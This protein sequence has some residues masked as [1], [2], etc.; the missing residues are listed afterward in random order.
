[1]T[2]TL[3]AQNVAIQTRDNLIDPIWYEKLKTIERLINAGGGG[4]GGG[5]IPEAP[6]DGSTYGRK[7]LG[8]SKAL[9]LAGGTLTGPLILAADPTTALGTATKQYVDTHAGGTVTN[10]GGALTLNDIVL[11][12]GGND[13]K[14][15]GS[16]GT[17]TTLLHGNASGPPTFSAVDLANDIIGNLAISHLN[18]SIGASSTTFWRGD[19]T[20]ATPAGGGGGMAIGGAVISGTPGSVLFIDAGGN[21][22]QDNASFFWDDTNYV[23]GVGHTGA[24]NSAYNLNGV[25]AIFTIPNASGNNWFEGN[26]GNKTLTG[27]ANFGTGDFCL[28]SVTNAYQNV[29]VGSFALQSTQSDYNNV[30]LGTYA[31]S[32]L[33]HGGV[34]PNS[35]NFAIGYNTMGNTTQAQ[36]TIAIGA[37]SL[38][39]IGN[40][41]GVSDSNIAIGI[42]AGFSLGATAGTSTHKNIFIGTNSGSSVT[43][44]SNYNVWIG[45]YSGPSSTAFSYTCAISDGSGFNLNLDFNVT[46][47]AVW[48]MNTNTQVGNATGANGLHIYNMQ[49]GVAGTTNYERA[50]LDWNPHSN[51]FNIGSQAGGTGTIRI[52][53]VDGFQK[54]GAPVV[55]DLPSGTWGLINDTSGGNTWLCYNAA[56]TLRKVQLV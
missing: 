50:V 13:I 17:A 10:T 29:G 34:G 6:N 37:A 4:G 18:S 47:S 28:S 40:G 8:W 46:H 36:G 23:L 54:A 55:G 38:S 3:P 15:L 45:G 7:N 20:W 30:A 19:G 33:G 24:M 43:G 49:N 39:N 27:Y 12:A 26:A 9:D 5:G 32:Q 35:D 53:A 52:I 2:V 56:G 11:G 41:G 14:V 31:L 44:I 22:G 16:L 1:V 25:P 42:G 51:I 21:L 48:S